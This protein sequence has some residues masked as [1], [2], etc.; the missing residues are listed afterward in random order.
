MLITP[1]NFA[2]NY[3]NKTSFKSTA[4][5]VYDKVNN[6]TYSRYTKFLREDLDWEKFIKF[7]DKKYANAPKVNIINY[8]SSDGSEPWSLGMLIMEHVDRPERM[9]PIKAF[10]FDDKNIIESKQGICQINSGDIVRLNRL[11]PNWNYKY[12]EPFRTTK[13]S[14]NKGVK[15]YE[16]FRDKV[17]FTQKDI[18]T[19]FE[20]K[21]PPN[22]IV[23]CRNMWPYLESWQQKLLAYKLYDALDETGLLVIGDLER[24]YGVLTLLVNAGFKETDVDGV[25]SK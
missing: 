21:L 2:Y 10:D 14:S 7:I 19:D 11:I 24:T 22:T 6:K 25:F 4:T 9:L 23:L 16:I 17:T 15:L 12:M 18:N 3:N 20:K 8:A 13:Y 5:T 1:I